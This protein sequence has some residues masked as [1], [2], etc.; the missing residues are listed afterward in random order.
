MNEISVAFDRE[1][2]LFQ[3]F[4]G[5]SCS[6]ANLY[7]EFF[8]HPELLI[9]PQL[10]FTRTDNYHLLSIQKELGL[11]FL[12]RRNFIQSRNGY[13]TLLTYGAVR[14]LSSVWAGGRFP[15][16]PVDIFHATYYRPTYY[17]SRKSKKLA[18]TI[19]DFI[20]EKLGWLGIRNPHIGKKALAKKADL[21]FCV[22]EQTAQDLFDF[23][24]ISG[25][26]VRVVGH[27]IHIKSKKSK[28]YESKILEGK[29]VLY[30]GHRGGYKNFEL[31]VSAIKELRKAD[32][33]IILIVAG[34]SLDLRETKHLN[35][36][37]G[38]EAWRSFSN[39]SDETLQD[40]YFNSV[41]HCVTS[42]LEGFGMTILESMSTGTPVVLSDLPVFHEVA[43]TAGIY[44]NHHSVTDLVEKISHAIEGVGYKE[45]SILVRNHAEKFSWKNSAQKVSHAYHDVMN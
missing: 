1:A 26:R 27:G 40:L 29:S 3:N 22:S 8:L 14:T 24:R 25:D 37:L 11:N 7:K 39:P 35:L 10:Q 18:I 36:M 30:V 19:H 28:N 34:K 42:H 13:S 32:R 43:G 9:K 16:K 17:E 6:F 33:T 15:S 2:F 38:P 4:G 20:P 23:Y 5:I 41:I 31:L 21:I 45:Q 44:F 12:P